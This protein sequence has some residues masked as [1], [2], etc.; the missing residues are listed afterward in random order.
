MDSENILAVESCIFATQILYTMRQLIITVLIFAAH[1]L[2]AVNTFRFALITDLHIQMQNQ[3][4]A[5]DLTNAISDINLRKDIDFVVIAGDV[6]EN[7]DKASLTEAKRIISKLNIPWYITFGNHEMKWSES[8]ATDYLKIF[9]DDKFSFTHKGYCFIGFSTGPVIKMGDGHVAPQDIE[10]VSK[11]L[12][13]NTLPVI[14]VTHYPLQTGDVDNWYDMTDVLRKFNTQAILN[15]HYHRNALLNYDGIPGIVNRSTLRAKAAK[16]GYS[17][18]TVSDSIHVFEK[19]IGNDEQHWLSIPVEQKK[20]DAPDPSLRP[21]FS[22]NKTYKKVSERWRKNTGVGIY[23][24]AAVDK[25]NAYYGNDKGD[26]QAV[27]LKNGE[28]IWQF[29]TGSRIIS[30]PAVSPGKVVFGSTN[31]T[32]YC[33]STGN[34]QILWK[35]ETTKAVM[36]C[37]LIVNDTVFIGGSDHCFRAIS[38]R[39]GKVFWTFDGVNGYIETRAVYDGFNVFFGAWDSYFYALNAQNGQL[40]WKWNNGNPRMHFSPAAVLPVVAHQKVFITAPD[41]YFTALNTQNGT[42]IWR[43]NKHEVR[44]TVG[45]SEDKKTVY[46]KCMNDSVVAIDATTNEPVLKWKTNAKFGYDH[47]ACMPVENKG[48]LIFGT[49]NGLITGLKSKNGAISWQH[50]I[51]NSIINTI[52]PVSKNECIVT[53]TEGQIVRLKY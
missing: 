31:G 1:Q 22:I 34:G 14:A 16:G 7:G 15:G 4:P 24:S 36:G 32:I 20:Y 27:S 41:R 12:E 8:G 40:S 44:E 30:S 51:G 37:P 17:I 29:S 47:N 53:T 28:Q 45:L 23:T 10:W 3:Q 42:V 13:Q 43:T 25:K 18:Y 6:T 46:S 33:L 48:T 52:T 2:L 21:D 39:D 9:G 19:Q 26:F 49:K 5:E 50:K 11:K 35:I 38:L